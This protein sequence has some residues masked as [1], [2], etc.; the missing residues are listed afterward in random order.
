MLKGSIRWPKEELN[1]TQNSADKT[2]RLIFF[3]SK[4][5]AIL[6]VKIQSLPIWK[7]NE[8]SYK[9]LKAEKS[10]YAFKVFRNLLDPALS[11]FSL[12]N[13]S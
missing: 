7:G 2:G 8:K 5:E 9:F 11:R 13:D 4:T 1:L 3:K 6:I 10:N 12:E